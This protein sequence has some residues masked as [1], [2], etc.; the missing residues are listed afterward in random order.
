MN[1]DQIKESMNALTLDQFKQ[2]LPEKMKKSVNQT[3]LD[4]INTTLEHPET[5]A[6]LRENM[7][8]YTSVMRDGRFKISSYIS[9]VK[10]CSFKFMGDT[11]R[12][13]YIRTFP[14]KYNQ[15]IAEGVSEKD[16]ASYYTAYNKSKL[17]ML[18]M[19]QSMIPVHVLNNHMF[20]DA[21]NI[22]FEIASNPDVAPKVRSD[23]ANSLIVNLKPPEHRKIE[24]D[25][26]VNQGSVI[27]DYQM[28]M[29]MMV[30]KQKELL[31]QGGDLLSIANASVK[32][33]EKDIIDVTPPAAK[34]CMPPVK[35]VD[36]VMTTKSKDFLDM[37]PL[38]MIP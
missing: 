29:V 11:N 31:E 15:F 38:Q 26:G 33:A 10:Y 34:A 24:I 13:A 36:P 23:A 12:K 37:T 27:E 9:A 16:I 21:L 20:Q 17:V 32:W 18:I 8:S 14:D 35:P 28:A 1:Q 19:E 7:L 6:I 22:Q 4:Q 5:M 25:V 30:K 3:L 2:V